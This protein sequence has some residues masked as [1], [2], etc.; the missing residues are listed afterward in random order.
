MGFLFDPIRPLSIKGFFAAFSLKMPYLN[1]SNTAFLKTNHYF[2]R[3]HWNIG[4]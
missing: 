2:C 3:T 1:E 4:T